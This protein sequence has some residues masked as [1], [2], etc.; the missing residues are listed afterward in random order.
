MIDPIDAGYV[1]RQM[2]SARVQERLRCIEIVKKYSGG[3]HCCLLGEHGIVEEQ[4]E[5][6]CW[7]SKILEEIKKGRA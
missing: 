4:Y 3:S 7:R 5:C 2:E 1:T 6:S